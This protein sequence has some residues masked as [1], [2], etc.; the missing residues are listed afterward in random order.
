M[1]TLSGESW[2]GQKT[3]AELNI[4]EDWQLDDGSLREGQL[5]F[6]QTFKDA[7]SVVEMNY[8]EKVILWRNGIKFFQ[9]WVTNMVEGDSDEGYLIQLTISDVWWWLAKTACSGE[10]TGSDGGSLMERMM[11][12][13][14]KG[15]LRAHIIAVIDRMKTL[16]VEVDVGGIS[17]M[18]D[19]PQITLKQSSG[20]EALVYLMR[21]LPDA[22]MWINHGGDVPT[23]NIKRREYMEAVELDAADSDDPDR[24]LD[25]YKVNPMLELEVT[26][27]KVPYVTRNV[28]G[29]T[30]FQEQVAGVAATGT[31]QVIVVSGPELDSY[32]P[33]DLAE[34]YAAETE[35]TND[36]EVRALALSMF[37]AAKANGLT[38]ELTFGA[39]FWTYATTSALATSGS[40]PQQYNVPGA[41]YTTA[42]GATVSMAGKYILKGDTPPDWAQAEHGLQQVYVRVKYSYLHNT[43]DSNTPNVFINP[44]TW[45][46][47]L[48]GVGVLH[49]GYTAGWYY[50]QL[51]GGEI[52][53]TV[54][55]IDTEYAT[56][57]A[58]YKPFDYEYYT[59]PAGFADAM[60]ATQNFTAY[61][62]VINFTNKEVGQVDY[63]GHAFNIINAR[64]KHSTMKAMVQGRSLSGGDGHEVYELG[65]PQ[66]YDY[67]SIMTMFQRTSSDNIYFI[68]GA[69]NSLET[70]G[71]GGIPTIGSSGG[72][73]STD[74]GTGNTNLIGISGD[75]GDLVEDVD[76]SVI[77]LDAP[78]VTEDIYLHGSQMKLFAVM[79]GSVQITVDGLDSLGVGVD[80]DLRVT[81]GV[82]GGIVASGTGPHAEP[83]I[84]NF[85]DSTPYQR[86]FWNYA[87][88]NGT[89]DYEVKL[90]LLIQ[91]EID[92]LVVDSVSMLIVNQE[93]AV[94]KQSGNPN[95]RTLSGSPLVSAVSL[96]GGG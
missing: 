36:L 1:W 93:G 76:D 77:S 75:D 30:V 26:Q 43:Q 94:I 81:F 47:D 83:V 19:V 25:S 95:S 57:T 37:D 67:R 7:A 13:F 40:N 45:H 80:W 65:V 89:R 29:L 5:V 42:E 4:D 66:R 50:T 39:R 86:W 20:A 71:S 22:A 38:S 12:G 87:F 28:N 63:R 73:T 2:A 56:E 82:S 6:M 72:S 24:A 23:I 55:V 10:A 79:N 16:G 44:P 49:S 14:G 9:G 64:T 8:V 70:D 85:S 69:G 41:T 90:T 18:F 68:S 58:L 3:L 21:L 34:S 74:N 84:H 78:L 48:P 51:Y 60:L 54:W 32:L 46:D 96:N 92:G 31:R 35:S 17:S 27:V 33:Y 52:S 62:G 15:D 88:S 91:L 61:Q 59:P 53:F 11:L